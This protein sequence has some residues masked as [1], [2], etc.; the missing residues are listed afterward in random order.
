[1]LGKKYSFVLVLLI[2][3]ITTLSAVSAFDVNATDD[4]IG[5]EIAVDSELQQTDEGSLNGG[6]AGTFKDLNDKI[7]KGSSNV[8][9]YS[10]YSYVC[11]DDSD[12]QQ[13]IEINKDM[14]IYGN[15]HTI[16]GNG[17]R[18]FVIGEN[19][20]VIIDGV[21]FVNTEDYVFSYGGS[22]YNE[23]GLTLKNCEFTNSS[24]SIAGG[25]I[26]SSNS[27]IIES[28]KFNNNIANWQGHKNQT[29]G[30][31]ICSVGLL[32]I[33][34]SYFSNNWA[35]FGGAIYTEDRAGIFDSIFVLNSANVTGGAIYNMP[36]A[37]CLVELCS[38]IYNYAQYG[39]ALYCCQA[40]LTS[41]TVNYAVDFG[42]NMLYG[43]AIDCSH[44]TDDNDYYDVDL[45]FNVNL[46]PS[47]TTIVCGE[48]FNVKVVD[49]GG[50][51][52]IPGITVKVKI[53]TSSGYKTFSAVTGYDGIAAIP[54]SGVAPN[55]YSVTVTSDRDSTIL[56]GTK[57]VK[58]VIK[59]GTSKI[60][61][62]NK[63]FK[64]S[65]K[66]KS[67]TVTLKD[68]KGNAIKSATVKITVN[69][70]TFTAKTTS[71]GKAT[72]KITKLT[73]KGNFKSTIKFAGNTYYNKVTKTVTISVR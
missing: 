23:G 36:D 27:L 62:S 11:P 50:G 26:F 58:L 52:P 21:K 31:A 38:F 2:I 73:K 29:L 9:L 28:S 44:L 47:K 18:I 39:G 3:A 41:F 30:G 1:M 8:Y 42:N 19:A 43:T 14:T 25:A 54:I 48:K 64:S 49:K 13:G 24:A 12:Y 60:T 63:A 71:T 72:F 22:I 15:G 57:S 4:V 69:G 70:K 56:S 35:K 16:Y 20:K 53:K 51:S 45:L 32:A 5:N 34:D 46:L 6:N 65:V 33:W 7:S 40:N 68:S 55:T 67:Y 17:A 61:A 66:T 10:D 37:E 59:K